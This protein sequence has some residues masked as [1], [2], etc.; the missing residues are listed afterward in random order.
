MQRHDPRGECASRE[1]SPW[2]PD[3]K[4]IV[5]LQI[6]AAISIICAAVEAFSA[7]ISAASLVSPLAGLVRILAAPK[8]VAAAQWLHVE[9]IKVCISLSV[10]LIALPHY[11][12]RRS[13]LSAWMNTHET[14]LITTILTLYSIYMILPFCNHFFTYPVVTIDYMFHYGEAVEAKAHILDHG[15]IWGFD[16]FHGAG[17]LSTGVDNFWQ[18]LF[19]IVFAPLGN[20]AAFNISV[21]V[22]FLLPPLL[23]YFSTRLFGISAIARILLVLLNCL[24]LE[25]LTPRFLYLGLIGFVMSTYLCIFCM[26][27][28]H[29]YFSAANVKYL[30]AVFAIGL[31]SL[32]VHPL[33]S[34][35]FVF[36][37]LPYAAIF[38]SSVIRH[39]PQLAIGAAL[40]LAANWY[41]WFGAFK[42]STGFA[43]ASPYMQTMPA[44]FLRNILWMPAALLIHLA[45]WVSIGYLAIRRNHNYSLI[46]ALACSALMFC[47]MGIFGS[48][49]GLGLTEPQRFLMPFEVIAVL[50]SCFLACEGSIMPSFPKILVI[51]VFVFLLIPDRAFF[52]LRLGYGDYPEVAQLATVLRGNGAAS[53]RVLVQ[54]NTWELFF[55]SQITGALPLLTNRELISGWTVIQGKCQFINDIAFG[56]RLQDMRDDELLSW[57]KLCRVSTIMVCSETAQRRMEQLPNVTPIPHNGRYFLFKFLSPDTSRFH[58]GSAGLAATFD[59]I[60]LTN[61]TSDTLVLAYHY[62]NQLVVRS[63]NNAKI[64]PVNIAPDPLPFIGIACNGAQNIRIELDP[65]R[66]WPLNR[67]SGAV[68]QERL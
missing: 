40:V 21:V 5:L 62:F 39:L 57:L 11:S 33:S 3:R 66:V 64:F 24:M 8:P 35:T 23:L 58:A 53:G 32:L 67:T 47:L 27:L 12:S 48:Q 9:I 16:P 29:R 28:L 31:F 59:K 45:F 20:P 54:D 18:A 10:L 38:H 51:A 36:L 6:L 26:A 22:A 63:G 7:T 30:L 37:F 13:A 49:M 1:T 34:I 44:M 25:K 68:R 4:T 14:A 17:R 55:D 65:W 50:I 2:V 61:P 60:Q 56:R 46:V 43:F 15:S 19:L 52:A 42:I 41:I